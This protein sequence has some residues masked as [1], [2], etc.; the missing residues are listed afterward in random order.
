[1]PEL[2]GSARFEIQ[3]QAAR[4]GKDACLAIGTTEAQGP[5]K[6]HFVLL[7]DTKRQLTRK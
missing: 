3:T 1:M 4:P 2:R 7:I 5:K 6:A